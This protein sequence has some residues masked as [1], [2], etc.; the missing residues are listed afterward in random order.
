M[1]DR[2][3]K[4]LSSAVCPLPVF[5]HAP[6]AKVAACN[7]HLDKQ[8]PKL[9]DSTTVLL[10][11]LT[12]RRLNDGTEREAKTETKTLFFILFVLLSV[13]FFGNLNLNNMTVENNHCIFHLNFAQK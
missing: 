7:G 2:Q 11:Y 6:K 3:Y 9:N 12:A 10:N 4:V 5:Y 1:A 8:N 13:V